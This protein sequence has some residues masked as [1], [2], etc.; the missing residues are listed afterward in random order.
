MSS[1]C[2]CKSYSHFFSK[3]ISLYVIFNNQSFNITLTNNTVSFE[4][5]GP[6]CFVTHGKYLFIWSPLQTFLLLFSDD[7]LN[8]TDQFI[9]RHKPNPE[10][11]EAQIH[12]YIPKSYY[13][14]YNRWY[15]EIL[16]SFTFQENRAWKLMGIIS[17]FCLFLYFFIFFLIFFLYFQKKG[18]DIS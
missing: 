10:L 14:F 5:L 9:W 4:Q 17:A 16:F 13:Y 3:N 11:T 18:V 2:K 12:T 15:F 1:F 6:E 7:S 8:K